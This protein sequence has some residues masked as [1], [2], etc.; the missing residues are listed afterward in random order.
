M[1][2]LIGSTNKGKIEEMRKIIKSVLNDV[3]IFSPD[4]FKISEEPDE[5]GKTFEENSL[6]KAKFYYDLTKI[7]TIADDGGLEIY[8]LNN[9]PGVLSRRWPG[10]EASDEELIKLTLEKLKNFRNKEERKACL[11][12]CVTYFDGK[13][14]L[15][16]VEKIEGYIAFE[17]CNK[18]EK[19]YP[20]RSLFIVLPLEKYFIELTEEEHEKFNHRKKALIRILEKVKNF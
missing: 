7:P 16:E 6:I 19:G 4:D 13:K 1:K 18:I 10:Y 20:F 9:E 11:K 12:T 3:E 14:I 5:N 8:S 2:I 15:Q 17:P